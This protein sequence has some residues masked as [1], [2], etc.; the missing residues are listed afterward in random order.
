MVVTAKMVMAAVV[1]ETTVANDREGG[2][3]NGNDRD[4]SGSGIERQSRWQ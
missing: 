1:M 2:G 3:G 4:G